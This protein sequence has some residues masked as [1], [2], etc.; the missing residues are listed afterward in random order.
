MD[1]FDLGIGPVDMAVV[2][3]FPALVDRTHEVKVLGHG[4]TA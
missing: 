3:A 2:A 1:V 4:Y